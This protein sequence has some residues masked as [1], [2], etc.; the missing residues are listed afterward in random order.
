MLQSPHVSLSLFQVITKQLVDAIVEVHSKGVF[1]RDIKLDN[2]LIETGSD[3]P[4]V[5]LIDFGCGTFLSEGRYTG[6]QGMFQE[7][8][9][10]FAVSVLYLC[11]S[12]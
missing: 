4:R 1:H 10:I 5:R 9:I 2:I 7:Q 6:D 11:V 8:R 12:H 3:V